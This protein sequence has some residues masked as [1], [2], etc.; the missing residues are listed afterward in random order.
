MGPRAVLY[1]HRR[2][3]RNPVV[4]A[5]CGARWIRRRLAFVD[6]LDGYTLSDLVR[7]RGPLRAFLAYCTRHRK[8]GGCRQAAVGASKGQWASLTTSI[9]RAEGTRDAIDTDVR[10]ENI[11]S[12]SPYPSSSRV[13]FADTR[14]NSL[15]KSTTHIQAFRAKRY[16]QMAPC[17]QDENN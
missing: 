15:P 1:A 12:D 14:N 8:A 5:Y 7:P 4:A 6:V 17:P 16:L 2:H 11:M 10:E 3:L 9:I 13:P